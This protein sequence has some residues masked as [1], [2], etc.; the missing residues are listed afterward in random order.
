[1]TLLKAPTGIHDD[2]KQ[3]LVEELTAALDEAY[4]DPNGDYRIFF[5]EYPPQN[6]GQNGRLQ[7][8]P[9]RP[10]YFIEGPPLPLIDARRKLVARLNA[11]L[12]KAYQDFANTREIMILINE[13][14]LEAAGVGGRLT[15]EDPAIVEA[16]VARGSNR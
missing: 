5:R 7:A 14:S 10:V 6:V 3:R 4:H 9:V 1:M 15:S 13:Y 12:A 11:A 2:A 8:E 16:T